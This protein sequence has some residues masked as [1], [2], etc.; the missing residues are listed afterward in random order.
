M[1]CINH[2]VLIGS[3]SIMRWSVKLHVVVTISTLSLHV[4]INSPHACMCDSNKAL[5]LH[6]T[7]ILPH[8]P[9]SPYGGQNY[10]VVLLWLLLLCGIH[11]VIVSILDI[12][13]LSNVIFFFFLKYTLFA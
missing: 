3:R 10:V 4:I 13:S 12:P 6:A 9:P 2:D 11:S 8:L 7:T 1:D 5:S